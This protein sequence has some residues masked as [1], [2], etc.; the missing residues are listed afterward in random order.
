MKKFSNF[1]SIV[2]VLVVLRLLVFGSF[3]FSYGTDSLRDYPDSDHYW[4]LAK[5]I[6]DNGTFVNNEIVTSPQAK[7]FNKPNAFR[8]PGYPLFLSAFWNIEEGYKYVP[9]VQFLLGLLGIYLLY[10]LAKKIFSEK[11]AQIASIIFLFEPTFLTV[12]F[13]I[14]SDTLFMVLF[15][16]FLIKSV[17]FFKTNN[18]KHLVLTG[19]LLAIATLV[20]PVAM[21]LP[22]LFVVVLIYHYRKSFEKIVLSVVIFLVAVGV[23]L[24]PW[25]IRNY[26]NFDKA[27]LTTL[28][29]YNSWRYYIGFWSNQ[30]IGEY[31]RQAQI[32][33]QIDTGKVISEFADFADP[34]NLDYYNQKTNEFLSQNFS[35]AVKNQVQ[36]IALETIDPR[37]YN[38][39]VQMFTNNVYNKGYSELARADNKLVFLAKNWEMLL[40]SLITFLLFINFITFYLLY[41]F[42]QKILQLSSSSSSSILLVGLI[43]VYLF[44][45]GAP[46]NIER[47]LMPLLIL[48]YMILGYTIVNYKILFRK[49]R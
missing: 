40:S 19:L 32:D 44:V 8:V 34:I 5:S 26:V 2:V 42:K 18:Y 38:Q 36:R 27:F 23:F 3:F 33:Y 39:I 25:Y 29:A 13:F 37:Y 30:E 35:L 28:P 45:T 48:E 21:Y 46:G 47:Y 15:L 12:N 14:L 41:L 4:G 1:K 16:W 20:R 11:V 17:E 49:H 7:S 24:S 10:L 9:I 43:V 31:W 6:H 22:I